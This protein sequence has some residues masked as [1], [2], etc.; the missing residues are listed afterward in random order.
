MAA[1]LIRDDP[2]WWFRGLGF[3]VVVRRLRVWRVGPGRLVAVVTERG[4]GT[5]ITNAAEN[6]AAQLRLE[7]P[8]GEL[9]V[10]EH[11]PARVSV[12][13]G[14]H[15]DR[16]EVEAGAGV[17]GEPRWTRI[18]TDQVVARLGVEVLEE[19]RGG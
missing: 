4:D 1:E 11:W 16:V 6:V 3:Q 5:S 18:P 17:W 13:E 9:E 8:D 7:Y 14:E 15:F 2:Q 19:A 12:D 10:V